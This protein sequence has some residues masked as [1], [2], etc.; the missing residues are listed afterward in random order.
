M[1]GRQ[2][3]LTLTVATGASQGPEAA[4]WTP[5]PRP[6]PL[7]PAITGEEKAAHARLIAALGPAALWLE[8]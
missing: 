2:P 3:D 5:P 4:D 7:V 6:R 8:G 1:G